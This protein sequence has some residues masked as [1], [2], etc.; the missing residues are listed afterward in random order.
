MRV[1]LAC[2]AAWL[3]QSVLTWAGLGFSW[4]V[5]LSAALTT[6]VL[7]IAAAASG[8]RGWPLFWLLTVL[9]GGIGVV[10]IQIESFAFGM[11]PLSAT[12]RETLLQ[13]VQLVVV[14]AIVTIGMARSVPA[15]SAA[16]AL[17]RR[18]WLRLPAVALSY[19]VLYLVAGSLIYPF[20]RHFYMTSGVVVIPSIG[21]ILGVQF[22]R[23]LVYAAALLP[24]LRRMA[25]RRAH[26]ALVAG[27]SLSVFGGIAPLLLPVDSILPPEVRAVHMIEI[28]GSNFV[29]GVIGAWLLVR[30]P[31][32]RRRAEAVAAP[33]DV[34]VAR[35]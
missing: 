6:G 31:P 10:N 4:G 12:V 9:C 22:L 7:Y 2:V 18:L 5:I 11:A 27:L 28:L 21:V 15:E 25:G 34:L 33:E 23:G 24:L 1:F 29:L 32:S 19:M 30:R 20:V 35:V 13:L 17:A 26:A 3:V 8:A 14:T 16:P